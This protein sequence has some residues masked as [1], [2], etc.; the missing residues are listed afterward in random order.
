MWKRNG[1][2]RE[3]WFLK[4]ERSLFRYLWS[5]L[6]YSSARPKDLNLFQHHRHYLVLELSKKKAAL[7][8]TLPLAPVL[9]SPTA[10]STMPAFLEIFENLIKVVLGLEGTFCALVEFK[11]YKQKLISPG[12]TLLACTIFYPGACL[13]TQRL[14][15]GADTAAERLRVRL[16][17]KQD[18]NVT[19]TETQ[20][21]HSSPSKKRRQ[22]RSTSALSNGFAGFP[23]D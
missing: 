23:L 21:A 15:A 5:P 22:R 13:A 1:M 12:H 19:M 10:I 7:Q 8:F 2:R 4:V 9:K 3:F 20:L 16:R 6:G 14:L 17:Q 18:E 11:A